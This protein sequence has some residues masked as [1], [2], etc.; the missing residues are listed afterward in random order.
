MARGVMWTDKLF[1]TS[2]SFRHTEVVQWVCFIC[3][4]HIILI[5]LNLTLIVRQSLNISLTQIAQGR[6]SHSMYIH[7]YM[8]V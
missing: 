1:S 4:A 3:S 8:F 5:K 2:F 7:V 6:N